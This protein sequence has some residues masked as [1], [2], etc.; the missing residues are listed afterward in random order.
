ML[1]G[2]KDRHAAVADLE[3]ECDRN[4]GQRLERKRE[5]LE[6]GEV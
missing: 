6:K 5:S 1:N 2:V 3:I 4:L